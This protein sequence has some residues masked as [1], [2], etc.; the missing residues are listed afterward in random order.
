MGAIKELE[1]K[2]QAEYLKTPA[3][4][5]GA[6]VTA[7][8]ECLQRIVKDNK[9]DLG[10]LK[11][12]ISPSRCF[13]MDDMGRIT[14]GIEKYSAKTVAQHLHFELRAERKIKL[15]WFT[16]GGCITNVASIQVRNEICKSMIDTTAELK[17]G[18]AEYDDKDKTQKFG[19]R[20]ELPNKDATA[21]YSEDLKNAVIYMLA[22]SV[23]KGNLQLNP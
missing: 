19:L 17:P 8:A 5:Y 11:V 15:C 20:I 9:S 21:K 6:L 23:F 22:Q 7:S 14:D 13:S 4:M 18:Y 12:V 2:L 16:V 1:K 3:G 10:D